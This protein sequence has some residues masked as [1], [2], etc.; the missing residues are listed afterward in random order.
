M[1]S[2]PH[3]ALAQHPETGEWQV[4]FRVRMRKVR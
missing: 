1:T 2:T 4:C 3:F